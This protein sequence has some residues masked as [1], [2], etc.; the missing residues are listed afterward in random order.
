MV[1]SDSWLRAVNGKPQDKMVTKSEREGLSVRVTAK[2]K[3]IF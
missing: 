3:V 1:V 2:G